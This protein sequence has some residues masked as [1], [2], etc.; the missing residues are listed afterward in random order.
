MA[1]SCTVLIAATHLLPALK[2]RS[3]ATGEILTFTDVQPIAALEAIVARR[4]QVVALERLF[5]ATPRGAALINRI[6]ADPTLISA[7]IRVVS[8]D[9][10]YSRV[11]PRRHAPGAPVAAAT[12]AALALDY[13]GTRRERRFPMPEGSEAIVNGTAVALVDLSV[14]GAQVIAPTVLRPNH[15]VRVM[16]ADDAA[17]AR[18]GGRVAWASFELRSAGHRY[19]G[20]IEFCNAGPEA[21][22]A[23]LARHSGE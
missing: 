11:S 2:Q 14:I 19:R 20:G 5:A 3:G 22:R 18:F 7:E 13:R 21:I 9:S 4:P 6:K 12:P 23:F 10:D 1:D 16:L 8:H 17:V 15:E